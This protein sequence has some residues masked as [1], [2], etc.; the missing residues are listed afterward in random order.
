[1]RGGAGSALIRRRRVRLDLLLGALVILAVAAAFVVHQGTP[2]SQ[3]LA[4]SSPDPAATAFAQAYLLYLDG[5]RPARSLPDASD[6]VRAIAGG[7]PPIPVLAR[8]GPVKLASMRVTYVRGAL[9]AQAAVVGRDRAHRFGFPLELRYLRGR[10]QVVY[11]IPPDVY[12]ITATPY[13]QPAAPQPLRQAAAVFALDYAEYREGT[14]PSPPAGSS[15]VAQQIA[16]RR[17]PLAGTVP[18]HVEPRVVSVTFGPVVGGTAA[19][20]ATLTDR[21][22]KLRFGFDLRQ[23]AGGW[24]A[25][26]FPEAG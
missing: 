1:M 14:R 19:A 20:N 7:A 3:H 26:G 2:S 4:S 13:R 9:S 11:M 5:A 22:R 15:T 17:D 24:Q 21:G 8:R 16:A 10:W 12:T 23:A 25:W 18:S 6:R